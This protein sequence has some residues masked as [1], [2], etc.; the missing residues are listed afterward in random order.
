MKALWV[1]STLLVVSGCSEKQP[2]AKATPGPS[3]SRT[4]DDL[5]A[6][7]ISFSKGMAHIDERATKD[8]ILEEEALPEVAASNPP[9]LPKEPRRK[10]A[11]VKAPLKKTVDSA[12]VGDSMSFRRPF[13]KEEIAQYILDKYSSAAIL[14]AAKDPGFNLVVEE[15][16]SYSK[17]GA[18]S[19]LKA[20][21]AMNHGEPEHALVQADLALRAPIYLDMDGS[22]KASLIRC[23]ALDAIKAAKP[24][25]RADA[26]AARAWLSYNLTFTP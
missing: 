19:L 13:T 3:A 25:E 18:F 21:W 11:K 5:R 8:S 26:A 23:K 1:L 9:A 22:K 15:G 10:T 24:S 20:Q 4:A 12:L 2:T 6:D 14:L 7:L 16:Q 17:D